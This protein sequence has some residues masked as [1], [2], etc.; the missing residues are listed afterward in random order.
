MELYFVGNLE[1]NRD[2]HID[3]IKQTPMNEH[4]VQLQDQ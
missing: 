4:I 2:D 3:D 1:T